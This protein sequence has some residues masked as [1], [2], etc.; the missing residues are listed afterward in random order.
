[1]ALYVNTNVSSINAQ[2]KLSNATLNL[3]T[4]YQRLSSGLRINSAKD[5]AAGLQIADRLTSQINGLN[6]GNRNTND[7]IA[8]AQTIEGALDET[9][10]MLQRIRVLAVQSANGTNSASDR[11]ALQ[12]EV[13]QLSQEINRIARQT[14]F[15]GATVLNGP[16][17]AG[18]TAGEAHL[19]NENSLIP[20]TGPSKNSV[21]FQVGANAGDTLA[22]SW[23]DAFTMSGLAKMAGLGEAKDIGANKDAQKGIVIDGTDKSQVRWTISAASLATYTLANIDKVIQVVDSK[24]AGLGALQNRMESAIRNQACISENEA[25]ARSRI[26]DTDFAAETAALTQGNIIQQASQT[27]LAQANQR[28]TIALSLLGR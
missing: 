2:R 12:E 5:D 19:N 22:L 16:Y 3:N 17:V 1:M 28:P 27:V 8:L 7:G 21:L 10:N 15:A 24:R 20:A 9:T 6:Q 11:K 25:D 18:K 4:S 26:R 23:A 14:T 13:T